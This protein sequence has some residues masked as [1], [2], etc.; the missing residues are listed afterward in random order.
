MTYKIYLRT[1]MYVY[2]VFCWMIAEVKNTLHF[3]MDKGWLS[4]SVSVVP[5]PSVFI[6]IITWIKVMTVRLISLGNKQSSRKSNCIAHA[7]YFLNIEL[8]SYCRPTYFASIFFSV[9][10]R[11]A[12][13]KRLPVFL[14]FKINKIFN[15][16][17][18]PM[19]LNIAL[20][21]CLRQEV[22]Y[23]LT[24]FCKTVSSLAVSLQQS[25][26]CLLNQV[27]L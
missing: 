14:L 24:I 26:Y 9:L 19:E 20:C 23:T 25:C 6:Q 4:F 21:L 18:L 16:T 1:A 27:V 8:V 12:D 2:D 13:K 15:K 10:S 22:L 5:H 17:V 3:I 11:W 7:H